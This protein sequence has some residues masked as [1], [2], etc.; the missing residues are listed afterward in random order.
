MK[1]EVRRE[2]NDTVEEGNMLKRSRKGE[3][4]TAD[5]KMRFIVSIAL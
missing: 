2:K 3:Q 5:K 4:D 1:T